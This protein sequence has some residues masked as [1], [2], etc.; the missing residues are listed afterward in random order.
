MVVL[1]FQVR[2]FLFFFPVRLGT[3]TTTIPTGQAAI[4]YQCKN[5]VFNSA[6]DLSHSNSTCPTAVSRPSYN[7]NVL[8]FY[9]DGLYQTQSVATHSSQTAVVIQDF[10]LGSLD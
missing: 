5:G 8:V 3:F 9:S 4:I 6:T 1:R 10:R 7:Q 2:F